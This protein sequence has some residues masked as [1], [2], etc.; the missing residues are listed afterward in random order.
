VKDNK[1]GGEENEKKEKRRGEEGK[2]M[3]G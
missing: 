1:R 2:D 3:E